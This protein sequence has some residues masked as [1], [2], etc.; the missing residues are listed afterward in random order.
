M[1][2][3]LYPHFLLAWTCLLISQLFTIKHVTRTKY[4]MSGTQCY[5]N[6]KVLKSYGIYF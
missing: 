2:I 1:Y 3:L 4:R 6:C 5:L